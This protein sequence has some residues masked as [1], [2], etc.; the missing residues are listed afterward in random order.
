MTR[1]GVQGR[2]DICLF[3]CVPNA[4][5]SARELIH[6]QQRL[7]DGMSKGTKKKSRESR[8]EGGWA[9]TEVGSGCWQAGE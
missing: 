1:N 7:V 9:E 2:K 3:S 8:K 6:P 5:H 4:Y